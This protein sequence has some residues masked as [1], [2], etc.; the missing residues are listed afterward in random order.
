SS[1]VWLDSGPEQEP[2]HGPGGRARH[3]VAPWL[4]LL[5]VVLISLNLRPGAS[6]VG[7]VLEEVRSAL[8]MSGPAAGLLAALPGMAFGAVGAMAVMIARRVGMTMGICLGLAAVVAGLVLRVTTGS[9]AVFLLFSIVAL[10]GM[11]VGNVL[12]PAWIKRHSKDG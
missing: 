12:V 2:G 7:P 5:A 4:I 11:A 8:G 9:T 3:T 1:T 10:A 6:S